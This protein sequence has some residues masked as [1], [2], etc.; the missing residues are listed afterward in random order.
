MHCCTPHCQAVFEGTAWNDFHNHACNVFCPVHR[1]LHQSVALSGMEFEWQDIER[2]RRVGEWN[3]A[4]E[5]LRK[6]GIEVEN[7][8]A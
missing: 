7:A 8:T 3:V 1:A 4:A 2:F 5:I 6:K